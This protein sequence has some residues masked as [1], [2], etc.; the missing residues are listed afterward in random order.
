MLVV[1]RRR[2]RDR[3]RAASR[4]H[5][6]LG[7]AGRTDRVT[8]R[9][10]IASAPSAAHRLHCHLTTC[11]LLAPKAEEASRS[12]FSRSEGEGV[13]ART[14]TTWSSRTP[15]SAAWGSDRRKSLPAPF[16]ICYTAIS[17]AKGP[18]S[19]DRVDEAFGR[20]L[21]NLRQDQVSAPRG[22]PGWLLAI[23]WVL[24]LEHFQDE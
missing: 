6:A 16:G 3:G 8:A 14:A 24:L 17:L 4:F 23:I 12:A 7:T 5:E 15:L 18:P 13:K 21:D 20:V 9:R 1:V 10:V 2:R 11:P 22:E 19:P